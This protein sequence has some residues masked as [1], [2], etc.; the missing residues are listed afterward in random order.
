MDRQ[1]MGEV[2]IGCLY[3]LAQFLLT[4]ISR[5]FF[6][7]YPGVS[8]AIEEGNMVEMLDMLKKGQMDLAKNYDAHHESE[9]EFEQILEPTPSIVLPADDSMA[10]LEAI[11]IKSLQ[12]RD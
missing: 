9:I 10:N 7:Q 2:R 8:S 6:E 1:L 4:P 12:G 3:P 11:S 5:R